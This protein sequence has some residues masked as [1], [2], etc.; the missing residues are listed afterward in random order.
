[1]IDDFAKKFKKYPTD[2]IS[3]GEGQEVIAKEKLKKWY[4]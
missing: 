1:M 2:K 4:Y 3:M